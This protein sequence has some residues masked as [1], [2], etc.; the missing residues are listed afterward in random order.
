MELKKQLLES[1]KSFVNERLQTVQQT[2]S[3]NQKALTSEAK[4][5]AGDKHETGRAMLQLEMEK[6]S[7]QLVGISEM[8][9][10]L[11]KINTSITSEIAHLGSIIYT[12]SATYFLSISA[13]QIVIGDNLYFA[14]SVSSPIG[15]LLLG[16]SKGQTISFNN[17]KIEIVLI[18]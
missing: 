16:K 1:C 12:N 18:K 9:T 14:I 2:I 7:Q 10:I 17:K 8:N 3:S 6:A 5:S 13:G 11:S 4:S 15:K